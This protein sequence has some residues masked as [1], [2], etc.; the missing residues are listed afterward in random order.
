MGNLFQV[1]VLASPHVDAFIVA[2]PGDE[3]EVAKHVVEY[4]VET[5]GY[6]FLTDGQGDPSNLVQVK[7]LDAVVTGPNMRV[8]RVP[9]LREWERHFRSQ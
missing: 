2:H 5:L 3:K 7:R 6:V 1:Q 9:T 4:M 8:A